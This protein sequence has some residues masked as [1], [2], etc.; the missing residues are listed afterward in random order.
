MWNPQFHTRMCF[1]GLGLSAGYH[2]HL[3][4]HDYVV[5]RHASTII[6]K[7]RLRRSRGSHVLVNDTV[8]HVTLAL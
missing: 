3:T 5:E 2:N 8:H 4:G 7:P 1:S 6:N